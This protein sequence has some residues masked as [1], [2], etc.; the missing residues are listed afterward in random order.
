MKLRIVVLVIILGILPFL[1]LNY[2]Q[3]PVPADRMK[4]MSST[5]NAKQIGIETL[6]VHGYDWEKYELV[7][8]P[9][10]FP[11]GTG[12]VMTFEIPKTLDTAVIM[13]VDANTG[14]VLIFEPK[15]A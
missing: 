3:A 12:Y 14:K 4:D 11:E 13:S 8:G 9:T 10:Y 1:Y 7:S 5:E 15:G 6:K 2:I